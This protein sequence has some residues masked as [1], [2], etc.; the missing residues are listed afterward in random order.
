MTKESPE[1]PTKQDLDQVYGKIRLQVDDLLWSQRV[2]Q[3]KAT[4]LL[5]EAVLALVHRWNRV[6][7]REQWLLDRIE[8]AVRRTVNPSPEE[9]RDDEELPS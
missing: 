8:K 2:P 6:R 7:N 4:A 1:R 9:P 3:E 5:R